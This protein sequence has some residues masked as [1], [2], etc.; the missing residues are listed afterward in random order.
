MRRGSKALLAAVAVLLLALGPAGCGG[1]GQS[2]STGSE[3]TTPSSGSS[4]SGSKEAAPG[5]PTSKGGDNSIQTW[6]VEAPAAL[7][8]RLTALVQEFLDARAD[9]DWAEAC[10]FLAAE[11]RTTFEQ[12]IKGKSGSA[13]CAEGMEALA[14]GVPA[15]AFAP[16]NSEGGAWKIVSVGPTTLS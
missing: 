5:V 11:Q 4:Q 12:L 7:R 9:A 13:A 2:D 16:L 3:A 1:D 6:G 10:S 14:T 15:S 8:G